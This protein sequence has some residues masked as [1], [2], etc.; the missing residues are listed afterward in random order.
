M[1]CF[2][3]ERVHH[4]VGWLIRLLVRFPFFAR[5]CKKFFTV[6]HPGLERNLFGINFPNPV[7]VAAGFDKEGLLYNG[8]ACFGF[9]HVEVGTVTPKGQYGNPKPRLFRLPKDGALINRMGFNNHG[10]EVLAANLR[11]KKPNLIIGGN[12]GKNTLTPNH[13]TIE[14]YCHSFEALF[15][16]VDYFVLNVSC[17]NIANLTKLQDKDELLELLRAIQ[18]LNQSKPAPKPVLLKI[19]PDLNERQLDEIIE[20]VFETGLNGIIATNTTTSRIGLKT[21]SKKVEKVGNGGLS[22]SPLTNRSTEVIKYIY[23]RSDGKIPIIGVGGIL[24]PQDALEKIQAGASLIQVYTGFVYYGP[25]LAKRINKLIIK[26][27][28]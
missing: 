1:F 4:L 26:N 22:G 27:L 12:I 23:T 7:G 16:L 15:D 6:E 2:D 20:I 8:L 11:S 25:F 18:K 19:A 10:V 21:A 28:S 9:S 5:L 13:L 24:T 3:A 14:D 17:P